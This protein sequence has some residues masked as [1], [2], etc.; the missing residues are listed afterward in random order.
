MARGLPFAFLVE[1][2]ARHAVTAGINSERTTS[3]EVRLQW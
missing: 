3:L 2:L 1:A